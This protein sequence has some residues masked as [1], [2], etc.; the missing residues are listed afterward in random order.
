MELDGRT[1]DGRRLEAKVC[2]VGAG[3]CGLT[4][5]RS[6]DAAGIETILLET[7]GDTHE[8]SAERLSRGAVRGD[9]YA[10]LER[11]RRRRI[12]GTA[13]SWNT[14][15]GGEP[16]AKYIPLDPSDLRAGPGWPLQW[17]EL[18]EWYGEAQALCRLGAFDYGTTAHAGPERPLNL[19]GGVLESRAY[20]LGQASVFTRDMP[21]LLRTSPN[22]T[23]CHHATLL[24]LHPDRGAE[25]FAQAVVGA[26]DGTRFH[27]RADAFVLA[28]GA[29]ENARILLL[30]AA[31]TGAR[32]LSPVSDSIGRWFMEHPRDS[33]QV[34]LAGARFDEHSRFY[35]A[36]TVPSG[37]AILGRLAVTEEA[38]RRER[39]PN[40][41][42]TFLRHSPRGRVPLR[43]GHPRLESIR[44]RA[45][46]GVP[47]LL[48]LN[49]E[50][51]PDLENRI[52]LGA[53]RDSFGLRRPELNWRWGADDQKKLE[54]LR[55]IV[56]RELEAAELGRVVRTTQQTPDPNA[57]HH[58]GTT[59]MGAD[60][61]SSVVD[62]ACLVH[63]TENLFAVGGSV[64]P[65]AGYA[66]PTLTVVALTLRLAD[67]LKRALPR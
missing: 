35:A 38:R 22:V 44:P 30:S 26:V 3:P 25:R 5:A 52:V 55:R 62:A 45:P 31:G 6:L 19:G 4:L 15:V 48:R 32:L 18:V 27:V 67:H 11:T 16:G 20:Q 10:G 50:Q 39:L 47:Y 57:H 23:L 41:S 63:G 8:R 36:H 43:S 46:E 66:N 59:R 61:V 28:G 2:V 65:S 51:S 21:E 14:L 42:L 34:L 9:R 60:A 58:A 12:G 24:E 37:T 13:T 64:F 40:A 7:G 54:R 56:A 1:L 49:L 29:V 53:R 17:P 33:S